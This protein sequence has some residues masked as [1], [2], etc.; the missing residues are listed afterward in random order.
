MLCSICTLYVL[1]DFAFYDGRDGLLH[2]IVRATTFGCFQSLREPLLVCAHTQFGASSTC[3]EA[4]PLPLSSGNGITQV[5]PDQISKHPN[6]RLNE[7]NILKQHAS[8]PVGGLP[9]LTYSRFWLSP[10]F[11]IF[12]K[13]GAGGEAADEKNKPFRWLTPSLG[14]TRSCLHG[15]HLVPTTSA[16]VAAF[17]LDGTVIKS[18]YI[19]VGSRRAGGGKQQHRVVKRQANGLEWEWWR[20]VVPQKLKEA[21]DSGCVL[22]I[23]TF[24]F[25]LFFPQNRSLLFKTNSCLLSSSNVV[26]CTQISIDP[27][28]SLLC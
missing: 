19:E 21:H 18:A 12:E 23:T 22:L 16:R 17:D 25:F 27:T 24:C 9:L 2:S 5:I 13:R 4:H 10:V 6:V 15:V 14:P 11:P 8:A 7:E 26:W 3:L 20:A 28:G 1:F